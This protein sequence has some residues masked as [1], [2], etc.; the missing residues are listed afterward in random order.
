[1]QCEARSGSSVQRGRG[2]ALHASEWSGNSAALQWGM[3]QP[4]AAALPRDWI[5]SRAPYSQQRPHRVKKPHQRPPLWLRDIL[6][7]T[8]NQPP[9]SPGGSLQRAGCGAH[10]SG[11][12]LGASERPSRKP[13]RGRFAVADVGGPV[14]TARPQPRHAANYLISC[15]SARRH[16]GEHFREVLPRAMRQS[17]ACAIIA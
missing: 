2:A 17:V 4:A 3:S 11:A 13:P 6:R 10:A 16:R 1:M 5:A 12:D 15:V 8:W 14:C 7:P 9:W